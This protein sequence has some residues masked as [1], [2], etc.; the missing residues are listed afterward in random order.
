MENEQ[1]TSTTE[2]DVA[3]GWI[4]THW[5]QT[6]DTRKSRA[7]YQTA[8]DTAKQALIDN[9]ARIDDAT[10]SLAQFDTQEATLVSAQ[11]AKGLATPAP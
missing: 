5:T 7:D 1:T 9:Q 6:W 10:A 11:P 3:G 8:L 4:I 2:I